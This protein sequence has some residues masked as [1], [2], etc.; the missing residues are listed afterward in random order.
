LDRSLL[1]LVVVAAVLCGLNVVQSPASTPIAESSTVSPLTTVVSIPVSPGA[2]ASSA[3]TSPAGTQSVV[4]SVSGTPFW[5]NLTGP[6]A[7]PPL[8]YASMAYD[9]IGNFVLLFGGQSASAFYTNYTWIFANGTWSNI[10]ASAG[11]AP[12]ARTGMAMTFDP[13]DGYILAY[14]GTTLGTCGTAP[15][16]EC[17]STWEFYSG[18]WHAFATRGSAPTISMQLSMTYDAGASYVLATDGFGTWSYVGGIWTRLCEANCSSPIPAP[19]IPGTA[20][21]D[22]ASGFV[23]FI[24][25]N[26][27]WKFTAG[28]WTNIT[29]TSGVPPPAGAYTSLVYDTSTESALLFGGVTCHECVGFVYLNETWSFSGGTWHNATSASYPPARYAPSVAFD[30][31][32]A[33][34]VL[35]GGDVQEGAAG[36]LNDTWVWGPSPPIGEPLISVSPSVPLPGST[37][38]F[39]VSFTGGVGPF[40]YNWTFGDGAISTATSPSHAYSSEGFYVVRVGV[41]DSAGH[42]ANASLRVHV[43]VALALAALQASPSPATLDQPVNFTASASG[44]TPPYTYS[45]IFGDG[46]VGGNLSNIT[47]IYTTDGPF[48]AEVSVTD[49]VGGSAHAFLNVSIRLQALAGLT[50]DAGAPPLTVDF[51][52]QAQGGVS[53]YRYS[54]RF[55]DGAT[56]SSQNPSHTYNATGEFTVTLTVLD[57]RGDSSQTSL[58][59]RVGVPSTGASGT[60]SWFWEFV[61][62][63][64]GVAGVAAFWTGTT[65]S[66][67]SRRREGEQWIQELTADQGP[68]EGG[69]GR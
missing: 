36:N 5:T 61:V 27:T 28:A 15:I 63:I 46:G 44:G 35:F 60:P 48:L 4:G 37:A 2:P 56:S 10:T 33:V 64:A 7:P 54:W 42:S 1:A 24:G 17:N 55:G 53:P 3:T 25:G 31:S 22:S 62:P 11:P 40:S 67:R 39:N 16:T 68:P 29:L 59:V 50:T 6:V 52:G 51:V 34:V 23:L 45:W 69:P 58:T 41:N 9:P 30:A 32:D 66:R 13:V 14:G 57:S 19:D 43:Y 12:V 20:T 47:H 38:S 8:D 26:Y 49:A 65:L 21:Y 18:M